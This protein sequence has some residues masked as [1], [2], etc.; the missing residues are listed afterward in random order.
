VAK[1][2]EVSQAPQAAEIRTYI[3]NMV[4]ELADMADEID[5]RSLAETLRGATEA[6]PSH[7]AP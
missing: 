2:V 3:L 5:D 4:A 7:Q 6:G 1:S